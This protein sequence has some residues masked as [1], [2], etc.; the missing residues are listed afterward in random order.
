MITSASEK[1]PRPAPSYDGGLG[2]LYALGRF[3][4]SLV[5]LLLS[6]NFILNGVSLLGLVGPMAHLAH[7]QLSNL[8]AAVFLV[9]GGGLLAAALFIFLNKLKEKA[10]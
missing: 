5:F 1:A 7:P 6:I 10:A 4:Q 9:L 8:R 2:V 3:S